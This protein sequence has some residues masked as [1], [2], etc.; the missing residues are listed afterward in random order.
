MISTIQ[1]NRI[2]KYKRLKK[3]DLLRRVYPSDTDNY[4]G[5]DVGEAPPYCGEAGFSTRAVV[6]W[7]DGKTT[8]CCC[9]GMKPVT[10]VDKVQPV[11]WPWKIR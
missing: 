5:F 6:L 10:N 9:K 2:A 3:E 1:K 11:L 8:W 7:P 4:F